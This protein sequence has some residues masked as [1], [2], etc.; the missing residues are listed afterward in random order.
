MVEGR[1]DGSALVVDTRE[2]ATAVSDEGQEHAVLAV[3][4]GTYGGGSRFTPYTEN[5]FPQHYSQPRHRSS[6]H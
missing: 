1:D 3:A 2:K 6:S 5:R 4:I